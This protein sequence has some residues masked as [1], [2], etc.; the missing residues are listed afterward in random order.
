MRVSIITESF[1]PHMN[2]V[3]RSVLEIVR[4][5]ESCGHEVMILAPAAQGIPEHVGCTR[6]RAVPSVQM[7]GY[8]SVKVAVATVARIHAELVAFKPDVVHLASPFALGWQGIVA[9]NRLGIPVVAV[10]QTDIAAYA[11]RYGVAATHTAAQAH[12][13]RLH[14][15]ATLTLVPSSETHRD[16]Q[17][18]GVDRLRRWG[19]GVDTGQFGPEHRSDRWRAEHAGGDV[20]IGYVG[21][22][23]AEKQ[24]E[25]LHTL[26]DIP[27]TRLVIVGDGPERERLAKRLPEAVFLGRLDGGAL[28]TALASFDVFVHPGE[29]ETFGQTLQEAHASGVPVV[30]TGSGGP[31]DLVRPSIDGWLY[32]PG[33]M[34]DFRSRVVDLVGDERKRR[35]FGEAGRAAVEHRSWAHV[36]D[37]LFAMFDEARALHAADRTSKRRRPERAEPAVIVEGRWKRYVALGDSLSEGL[38]DPGPEGMYRGWA[39]RLALLLNARKPVQYANLA[40]RSKRVDEV[41]AQQL[42]HALALQP[43]LV[44]ILAGGNDLVRRGADLPALAARLE[45]TVAALRA[46]GADVLLVTPF[47]PDRHASALFGKKFAAF[48]SHVAG[49]AER[50]GAVL[51]DTDLIPNFGATEYWS[52]DLVHLNSAGHRLLAY[53]AAEL[54]GV[55]DAAVL[56]ALDAEVHREPHQTRR[57]WWLDHALP[58]VWRRLHG[59]RA[60]DGRAPK[61]STYIAPPRASGV[62]KT[63]QR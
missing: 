62:K 30:A 5:L 63:S 39:D 26:A 58:W 6:V 42:G 41:A 36:C 28:A 50:T 56:G 52:N 13:A 21:R 17:A 43:D 59:V 33:D 29:S 35:A 38:C 54:L 7:P 51:L 1:L 12:I 25:D 4:H 60:G 9:A 3:T 8:P 40:V 2:G 31:L 48:A 61:Y 23:A 57:A 46:T 24:V 16:L 47:C 45:D 15:R 27:G 10:Y 49:I 19:R 34:A 11:S 55:R 20:V 14:R 37:D 53:R 18:L 22:L 32:R 44:S